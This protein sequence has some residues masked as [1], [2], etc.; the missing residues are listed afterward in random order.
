MP[1]SVRTAAPL[2][3]RVIPA[4]VLR[5][6]VILTVADIAL[7]IRYKGQPHLRRTFKKFTAEKIHSEK[8]A[9]SLES[10]S[11]SSRGANGCFFD[12]PVRID[13][14]NNRITHFRSKDRSSRPAI[15]DRL[16]TY[17]YSQALA[18]GDG[19][20]LHAAAVVKDKKAF[21]F[22]G[23]SGAGKSTAAS[24]SKKYKVIGDD[25][26]A[27]KKDG[28]S[29]NVFPTPWKQAPFT[30]GSERSKAEIK[31]FFFIRR[32]RQIS[33][34]PV[35]PEEALKRIIYSHIHFFDYTR[36]PLLNNIFTTASC[37]VRDIPAYDME[38]TKE[39]DFWP[40]LEEAVDA[41][42]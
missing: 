8:S 42:R 32:S 20:L 33:F 26:V 1:A 15:N 18:P 23:R 40:E 34:K 30:K 36:K 14:K 4:P 29:Y 22:L 27:V 39:N 41:R 35:L 6:E 12:D 24:L 25:V 11:R 9:W 31:A 37:F 2:R 28:L 13:L 21:L 10:I 19:M 17:A 7:K 5:K 3:R 16:I 38:F